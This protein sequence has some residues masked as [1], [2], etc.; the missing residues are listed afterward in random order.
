[1][2]LYFHKYLAPRF[3]LHWLG[4]CHLHF[5]FCR[6][7]HRG[8]RLYPAIDE[9]CLIIDYAPLSGLLYKAA[10]HTQLS[11]IPAA[12]AIDTFDFKSAIVDYTHA[13][14]LNDRFAEAYYNRGLAKIYTGN[15]DGG[16]ADLSKAGELGMYQAYSVIK[17]FR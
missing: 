5:S 3:R 10:S 4:I 6:F 11:N 2:I 8:W 1:M 12:T 14:S 16:V 17:R 13:I 9:K 15:T 7:P